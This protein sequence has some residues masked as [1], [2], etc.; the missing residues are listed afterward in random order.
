MRIGIFTLRLSSNYGGIL[1]AYALQQVLRNIGHDVFTIRDQRLNRY[2]QLPLRYAKRFVLKYILR[3]QNA[4]DVFYEIHQR[5]IIPIITK[6]TQ[7]FI[8]K[9]IR[10]EE[11]S[12]VKKYNNTIDAII[13][14]SDQVWRPKYVGN[15]EHAYLSFTNG[16]NIKRIS[17]ASSFG[18]D[19]WE[20]NVRQNKK[21]KELVNKFDA[22]SVREVSGVYLCEK[23][24]DINA[25]HVLDPTMLLDASHYVSLIGEEFS[26]EIKED[27]FVYVLD[28]DE[29]S[30]M[31]EQHI[32]NFFGY[33]PF[34]S[35]TD[36]PS[37]KLED[38]VASRIETWLHSF[39]SAKFILTDSFHACVF[40]ILFNKPFVVYGN[41]GRGLSRF[42]SLLQTFNLE[43]RCI[44]SYTDRI[45]TILNTPIEWDQI[46]NILE[47]ERIKSFKFLENALNQSN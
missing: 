39:L 23:Y 19:K 36:N 5:K 35:S 38:R 41:I 42:D 32:C 40:S 29:T 12:V 43:D 10:E 14:G 25:A 11:L 47:I 21:A 26:E 37:A 1:Q 8:N 24:L 4:I 30:I 27:L 6:Q 3:K 13:V 34:Y 31:I 7:L 44:S 15:I 46:N 45:D 33:E 9:H 17:Y 28:K 2:W 18:T 16:W 22:V 20:Y